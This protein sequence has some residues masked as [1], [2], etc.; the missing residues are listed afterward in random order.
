MTVTARLDPGFR[1]GDELFEFLLIAQ[2]SSWLQRI[3]LPGT[4]A[5]VIKD[6]SRH[7]REGGNPWGWMPD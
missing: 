5:S 3:A 1:R 6:V 2:L 7:S 4:I